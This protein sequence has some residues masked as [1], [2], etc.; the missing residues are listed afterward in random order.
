M[1]DNTR[2]KGTNFI[3]KA[4]TLQECLSLI[5]KNGVDKDYGLHRWYNYMTSVYCEYIFCEFGAKHE[6][7]VYNHDVDIY[8]GQT[9]FDVKLTVYPAKLSD[10]PYDLRSRQGKNKMIQWYYANQSQQQRKQL[11]NR[12]YVVCDGRDQEERLR[13]KSDFDLLRKQISS[14]M[15]YIKDKGLNQITITDFGKNYQV[16]SDIIYVSYK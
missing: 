7:D 13:L 11:I 9:P 8:I 5:E 10:H 3:Y 15:S 2:D 12:L 16:Y 6:E 1:Q 4:Q 14:F